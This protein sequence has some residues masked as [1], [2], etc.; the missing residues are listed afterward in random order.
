M[1][2]AAA[3][4][5]PPI[6]IA[7]RGLSEGVPENTLAAFRQS[8]ERGVPII[9]LDLRVTRD[10]KLV[11]M[12]DLTVDRTTDCSGAVA[13]MTLA[14][15]KRCNAGHG[16]RVPT[17]EE[18]IA[19]TRGT[20]VRI[21][22]DVKYGTPIAPVLK[23]VRDSQVE[24]QVILGLRNLKFVEQARAAFP[25]ATILAFMP[26]ISDGPAFAKAGASIIRLWSDWAEDDPALIERTRALGPQ[27][28]IMVGRHLPKKPADWRALHARMIAGGAQG[29][30]TDRPDLVSK[31]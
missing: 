16:E 20:P 6:I 8:I 2:T 24:H 10:R 22:A 21:L 7:H 4:P 12:H 25:D 23:A 26:S 29:L 14:R 17:F 9:E 19:L 1:T 18:V 5:H 13:D 28:W 15:I 31:S 11:V 30:I 3:P 27:V